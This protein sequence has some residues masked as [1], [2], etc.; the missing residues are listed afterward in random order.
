MS[1]WGKTAFIVIT[2]IFNA[3]GGLTLMRLD[4]WEIELAIGI[5]IGSHVLNILFDYFLSVRAFKAA[6]FKSCVDVISECSQVMICRIKKILPWIKS[7]RQTSDDLL[8]RVTNHLND[9]HK[10]R[11]PWVYV[12]LFGSG[13]IPKIPLF[14]LPGWTAPGI[15]FI[16]YNSLGLRGWI[17]LFAG[18]AF[19]TAYDFAAAYGL[20]S[21]VS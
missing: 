19:R 21:L 12:L 5:V 14:F 2:T 11:S 20:F 17:P 13:A 16:R 6:W 9:L 7:N 8:T 18:L 10:R 3:E 15:F 4:H 1:K